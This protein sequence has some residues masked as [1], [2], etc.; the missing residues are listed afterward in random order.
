MREKNRSVVIWKRLARMLRRSAMPDFS[1]C[2][3]TI[4]VRQRLISRPCVR[5]SS[6]RRTGLS[7]TLSMP[8]KIHTGSARPLVDSSAERHIVLIRELAVRSAELCLRPCWDH[9]QQ[10]HCWAAFC[11]RDWPPP[12]TKRPAGSWLHRQSRDCDW[13]ARKAFQPDQ[14][15]TASDLR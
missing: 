4:A 10:Y 13:N 15:K 6:N 2:Q 7:K 9:S 12:C 1:V 8:W 5:W 3:C 11:F 14:M